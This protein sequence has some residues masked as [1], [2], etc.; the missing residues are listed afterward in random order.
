LGVLLAVALVHSLQAQEI[1]VNLQTETGAPVV[2][3]ELTVVDSAGKGVWFGEIIHGWATIRDLP[4][5]VHTLIVNRNRCVETRVGGVRFS[6][7]ARQVIRVVQ[8]TCPAGEVGLRGGSGCTVELRVRDAQQQA[9]AQAT[10]VLP[11]RQPV[12]TDAWGRAAFSV[13]NGTTTAAVQRAG[14]RATL[15]LHCRGPLPLEETVTLA[16]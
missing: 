7:T 9:V 16:P 10:V 3:A 8:N 14:A 6:V 4:F 11:G 1:R 12:V 5:G 2:R 13:P 15:A